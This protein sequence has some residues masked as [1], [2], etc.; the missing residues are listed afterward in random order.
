MK[1]AEKAA[2]SARV[3]AALTGEPQDS[4]GFFVQ[5]SPWRR[6]L[7]R[8]FPAKHGSFDAVPMSILTDV[9]VYLG[10]VDRL[11]ILLTGTLR[12]EIRTE[13][14]VLVARAKSTTTMYVDLPESL[15]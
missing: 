8:L 5:P 15:R 4:F 10:P 3:T 13:T 6:A 7:R 9:K 1:A 2:V 11:R 14:D 12:L